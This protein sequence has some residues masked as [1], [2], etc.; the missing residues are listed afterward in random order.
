ALDR[1]AR[2]Q[3]KLTFYR[4]LTAPPASMPP[5][6][7][8]GAPERARRGRGSSGR[9]ESHGQINTWTIQVAAFEAREPARA[10][11]HSLATEGF[12][13]YLASVTRE[14]GTVLYRVRVGN[15]ATRDAALQVSARLKGTRT[16]DPFVVPR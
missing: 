11:R 7:P 14:D 4:T 6:K 3:D 8:N 15:Y 12:D 1:S 9:S 16:L 5:A 13:A 2:I 10:L